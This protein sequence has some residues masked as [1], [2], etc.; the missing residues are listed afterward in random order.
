MTLG[1]IGIK[2]WRL[3]PASDGSDR[4]V[5]S[6]VAF[7]AVSLWSIYFIHVRELDKISEHVG[8]KALARLSRTSFVMCMCGF[9]MVTVALSLTHG[10]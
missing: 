8:Q 1:N 4:F 6:V 10:H 9:M 2:L 7:F 3:S 5:L